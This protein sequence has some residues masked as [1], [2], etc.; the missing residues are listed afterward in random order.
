MLD[1]YSGSFCRTAPAFGPFLTFLQLVRQINFFATRRSVFVLF[2]DLHGLSGN[3]FFVDGKTAL[4][5]M[6]I[7][8][9][10]IYKSTVYR[11]YL[12]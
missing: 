1:L 4:F 2:K 5:L 7:L 9:I 6:L 12:Q 11:R 10:Y 8:K 3:G